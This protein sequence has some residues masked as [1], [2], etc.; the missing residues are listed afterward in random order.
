MTERI[1]NEELVLYRTAT[2]TAPAETRM[3]GSAMA[4]LPKSIPT[5]R[6]EEKRNM[7]RRVNGTDR[8]P[9]TF[10]PEMIVEN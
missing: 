6:K 2:D 1:R 5:A 9:S 8:G 4:L 7:G 3:N 10:Y